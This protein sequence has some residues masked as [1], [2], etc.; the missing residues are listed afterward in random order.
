MGKYKYQW[1]EQ[2]LKKFKKEGR[3]IGQGVDYTPWLKVQDVPSIGRSSKSPGWKSKRIHHF[4]S[5]HEMRYFYL[6][7]WS[8]YVIDIR[9]QYPLLDIEDALDIAKNM[10]IKYP[11]DKES[12]TPYILTTD[13][14]VT[15]DY[16]GK[17][18]DIAR[19]IKPSIELSKKRVLE[20]F[21][22]ERRYWT[23][24][25]VDWGIVTEKEISK[26]MAANIEW[27]YTA[28]YLEP[29]FELDLSDLLII[30]SNLKINLSNTEESITNVTTKLDKEMN[31]DAGTSLYLFKHLVSRKEILMD[32]SQK[33]NVGKS[34]SA[35]KEIIIESINKE[36]ITA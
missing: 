22:I 7:E 27:I 13:F 17:V 12:G 25:G 5:D 34:A 33:I 1:N 30:A 6:L 36:D 3:G 16:G 18:F 21:E 14:M 35:I 32:M 20:K 26:I 10:G 11:I 24:R 23:K 19:T 29:T 15:V 9:E 8:D 2:K 31:L 28:Y 4:L